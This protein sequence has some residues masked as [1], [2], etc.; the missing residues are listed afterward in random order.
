ML[1]VGGSRVGVMG[2]PSGSRIRIQSGGSQNGRREKEGGRGARATRASADR[3]PESRLMARVGQ[4]VH[5]GFPVGNWAIKDTPEVISLERAYIMG[6]N[7]RTP[8]GG[9]R[10]W[11]A[12][13]LQDGPQ[14]MP[15]TRPTPDLLPR[16]SQLKQTN[17]WRTEEQDHPRP[18]T[19]G[20]TWRG[21]EGPAT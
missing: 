19:D 17:R 5:D 8:S 14:Y 16:W 4:P 13:G 15:R 20:R 3:Q 12:S 7:W 6:K 2:A 10:G 21:V 1:A 11:A 18:A 9:R